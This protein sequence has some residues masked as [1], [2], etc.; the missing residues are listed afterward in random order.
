MRAHLIA[1]IAFGAV[2][3]TVSPQAAEAGPPYQNCD[4]ARADGAAPI[5]K[6]DPGYSSRLDRDG[7][8]VACENSSRSRRRH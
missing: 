2:L 6:G 4:E 5:Q 3:P 7:D 8:G 1:A